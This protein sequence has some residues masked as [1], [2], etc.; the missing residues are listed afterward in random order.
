[1]SETGL[2]EDGGQILRAYIDQTGG[3]HEAPAE[4]IAA[5]ERLLKRDDA[6]RRIPWVILYQTT[7]QSLIVPLRGGNPKRWRLT[8]E[9]SD[10]RSGDVAF[11]AKALRIEAALPIGYHTLTIEFDNGNDEDVLVLAA[12]NRAFVPQALQNDGRVWGISIQL[13][14]LRS[15]R[16]WGIGDFS[17]LDSL[18]DRAVRLGVSVIGVNPLHALFPDDPE[19]ASPYS[20]NSRQFLNVLYL[21]VESMPDFSEYEPARRL[22]HSPEFDVELAR[23]RSL[24]YVDYGGV[25]RCKLRLFRLLYTHFRTTHLAG[26][27]D[28]RAQD[29]R[30]FQSRRGRALRQ[31]AIF[32]ALRSELSKNG[33]GITDWRSWPDAFRDPASPAVAE[34]ERQHGAEIEFAEYLQWQAEAQLRRC[35]EQC[36]AVGMPIG[37]YVD[38]A[39][40]VA[41]DSAEAWASQDT[42]AA[43]W[44][45]GAPP[46]PWNMNGQ[47]WGLPPPIPS[48]VCRTGYR[49]WRAALRA[50]MRFGG[51]I[52]IDHIFALL[53]LFWVP[54][55]ARRTSGAYVLY[56][57]DELLAVLAIESH[58]SHCL[59][60]GEDLGTVPAGLRQKLQAMNILSYR[61]LYFEK[62][63]EGRFLP[64]SAWPH[65]ALSA[66]TT[67]DLPTLPAYL[68]GAD[69]DLKA[70][71]N[72]FPTVDDQTLNRRARVV[73]MAALA[74]GVRAQGLLA[75][76]EANLTPEAIYHYL[77]AT[78]T[79]IAMV[80]PEDALG[81]IEPMNIPGTDREYPNWRRKLP[82]TI[83]TMC[84]DARM[85]S[86]ASVM[87][88]EGRASFLAPALRNQSKASLFVPRATY[89]V[90]FHKGFTF[91]DAIAVVPYLE[92]LGISHLYASPYL[93]ARPGSSHGYDIVDHNAFN[94]EVGIRSSFERL[95]TTLRRAGMGQL[96]DFVPN[97]MGIGRSDN[98]L[99]TDVL[100]WGQ[101]SPHAKFF[102]INWSPPQPALQGKILLPLLGDH[103][104]NVLERN[105][106]AIKFESPTGELSAWYFDH[107]FPLNPRTYATVL[108]RVLD[109]TDLV[110]EAK[111][112][113]SHLATAFDEV[114]DA[115]ATGE[116]R[117][118]TAIL[119]T[120]LSTF[121]NRNGNERWIGDAVTSAWRGVEGIP[122]S[123]K[124]LHQLLDEQV[125]RLA[126]WRTAAEDV[127]YRRFFDVSELAGVRMEAP[128]V[129]EYTHEF[130]G[131]LIQDG[132][133]QGLR[134]DHIDGLR[135]PKAYLEKLQEFARRRIG[136]TPRWLDEDAP[137]TPSSFYVVVEKIL[138]HHE[139]LRADW[140]V[141]GT[142]GY[143]FLNLV[144]GLFVDPEGVKDLTRLYRRF[145][146]R[147]ES[148]E[149]M[150]YASKIQVMETLLVSGLNGLAYDFDQLSDE[151]WRTRDYTRDRLR[152]AIKEIVA[153]FPVYRTYID[154]DG[155]S[156]T[157]RHYLEWALARARKTYRGPDPE[158][159][160]FV[161]SVLS[162]R[163]ADDPHYDRARILALAERFQQYTA[164]VMAKSLEDTSFY[165]FN[166]L[167]SANDVGGDPERLV[168]SPAAFHAVIAERAVSWPNVLVSTM[169]H[170]AK[171]GEDVRTRIDTLS[172][173]PEEWA[174]RVRRWSVINRK[175]K[176]IW[177]KRS[178]PSANDEYMIYQM[179][180]GT[181][182][183]EM[184]GGPSSTLELADY[185]ARLAAMVTKAIREAKERTSWTNPDEA[186]EQGCVDF[187]RAILDASG[188]NTFLD[189][190]VDFVSRPAWMGALSSLSQCV[191]KFSIPGVPDLYQGCE[192]WDLSMVD[193]DN[194]RPVDFT[195]RGAML[196]A[197]G[198]A[199]Q[200][201]GYLGSAYCRSLLESWRDGRIKMAVTH[202]LLRI[203]KANPALF[204]TGSYEPLTLIGEKANNG[205]ALSRGSAECSVVVVVGRLFAT[206]LGTDTTRYSPEAWTDTR[207]AL[208]PAAQSWRN[209]FTGAKFAA[210]TETIA[211]SDL[212]ADLPVA[213]LISGS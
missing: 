208:P 155:T 186:Y 51:A 10:E 173:Y 121:A 187:V 207:L 142:T 124:P 81:V 206:L 172:E 164:P 6:A 89:R 98:S 60:V 48:E 12:P 15:E 148:F 152:A 69:L 129:F 41:A 191:L 130:I 128:G 2:G 103:Y 5:L 134:I 33:R 13:F 101:A 63:S 74:A 165:R 149:D 37:L 126:F 31:F 201:T 20:P 178:A 141:S 99:W 38:I 32:E 97:H 49:D 3:R 190:F 16:N 195:K 44:S 104:G 132:Q 56:P 112:G 84:R 205:I 131:R 143:E 176:R 87:R 35:A 26:E 150:L 58:R 24:A 62:D 196:E 139:K 92:R 174:K 108:R 55:H 160:D 70:Q 39:V 162:I 78:P 86:I 64:P 66:V 59:V 171:R 102:D 14:A 167:I 54:H 184:I 197:L 7:E 67:H 183:A 43:G 72:L 17:D 11:G 182:P 193:P 119:K 122:D 82:L 159:L 185:G 42:I 91:E 157:D 90:Q 158:I 153:G 209:I 83:D 111:T 85:R 180:V 147:S 113:L 189:D 80:Q 156:A 76:D 34:F 79:M 25:A 65:L 140:P 166:R 212:L 114:R 210:N 120:E 169:T 46:D 96:L 154:G 170:D 75:D 21:D 9:N 94:P 106:I 137:S 203:R 100:E 28:A 27:L 73:E 4:T 151:H 71:L 138:A 57:V 168:T 22:R 47:D 127:N 116:A 61:L 200:R 136:L 181:W 192:L 135:D 19:R 199:A 53:R 146:K 204:A 179:M 93:K 163:L 117:V 68:S 161:D 107:K 50:N 145:S 115:S 8:M 213:V 40:G 118:R 18:I 1:M 211:L 95:T 188:R 144:N 45:I 36:R 202:S 123:F 88:R 110:K 175:H 23:L 125:Y 194:R 133:V 198:E 29:F 30:D 177:E 77:A 105:E 109:I 52:R